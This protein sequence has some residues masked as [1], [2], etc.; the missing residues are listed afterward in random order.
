MSFH[1]ICPCS[2]SSG[3]PKKS[4]SSDARNK[5]KLH[6][7]ALLWLCIGILM[8]WEW[9]TTVPQK[10]YLFRGMARSVQEHQCR[11]L[12][13]ASILGASW[14]VEHPLT[15]CPEGC[16]Q[17]NQKSSIRTWCSILVHWTEPRRSPTTWKPTEQSTEPLNTHLDSQLQSMFTDMTSVWHVGGDERVERTISLF[18]GTTE[19]S[20]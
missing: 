6:Y 1:R 20:D 14:V 12:L 13:V 7:R 3:Y 8:C 10:M 15:A 11:L 2:G 17:E 5:A 9:I 18:M 4:H 16:N 19:V